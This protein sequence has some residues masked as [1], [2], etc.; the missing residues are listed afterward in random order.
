MKIF[1]TIISLLF[2]VDINAQSNFVKTVGSFQSDFG[3]SLAETFDDGIAISI[4]ASTNGFNVFT[5]VVKTNM[6]GQL[7]WSKNKQI[8]LYTYPQTLVQ[9]N[10]SGIV[11]FGNANY[12][13]T[14]NGNDDFLFVLKTD[15]LGNDLWAKEYRFSA[16][17]RAVKLIKSKTGGYIFS[18][19]NKYN[20]GTYPECGVVR[21]EE[22]G[23][24]RWSK[25]IEVPYGIKP[26]S[27]VETSNGN[28]CV[29]GAV[30]GY[31]PNYFNDIIV[32]YLDPTGHEIWSKVFQTFYD[33]DC[34]FVSTNS[35][36]DLFLSGR[37]YNI[38]R[39]WDIFQLK[40]NS[41]GTILSQKL[42]DAG[43]GNGEIVR[44]GIANEDGSTVLLGDIGT[45]D[46]RD[47]T[48]LSINT[49]GSVRWGRKYPLSPLFTNYPYD[50]MRS[51][52]NGLLF[53]GDVRPPSSYRDAALIK[54]TSEGEVNCFLDT[55]NFTEYDSN[56]NLIVPGLTISDNNIT[57][58]NSFINE[59]VSA[60]NANQ[61]CQQIFPIA[62]FTFEEDT[63]CSS[64]CVRFIDQSLNQPTAWHW[65][66]NG[67]DSSLSISQNPEGIC[68]L[69]KG[70]YSISLEVSN[71]DGANSI[72]KSITVGNECPEQPFVI[73]NV[74]TPN[75]DGKNDSFKIDNL[76][77]TA[78]LIIYNR[79]GMQMF[80]ATP[81]IKS[82]NGFDSKGKKASDGVYYYV[83]TV[84]GTNYNGAIQLINGN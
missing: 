13:P 24:I 16:S 77:A 4:S 78:T 74:F 31:N 66:F 83:L 27:I 29:V 11:V 65:T 19:I 14:L 42:Y 51:F 8:G 73:P 47:I 40:L 36:G 2:A 55:V 75:G 68:F 43:T 71:S 34:N 18:T 61:I 25:K 63:L 38:A 15:S 9:S 33:D 5:S 53:T 81:T 3:T 72:T 22:D 48:M 62:N 32:C 44:T 69:T 37:S 28:I 49:D 64:N 12:N 82:W 35:S 17:D 21:I 52:D 60:V 41:N 7:V 80:R 1:F 39:E 20:L 54:T 23:S 45:F 76:P 70:T 67:A 56:F 50:I 59:P 57:P 84:S 58:L 46:E 30:V 6:N 26:T 79:W 10:D